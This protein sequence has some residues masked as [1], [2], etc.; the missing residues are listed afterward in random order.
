[1]K[2]RAML[3]A[4]L[5]GTLLLSTTAYAEDY[6]DYRNYRGSMMYGYERDGEFDYDSYRDF[7]DSYGYDYNDTDSLRSYLQSFDGEKS[8][9]E[10]YLDSYESDRSYRN[11]RSGRRNGFSSH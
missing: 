7:C 10:D 3:S 6:R 2:K 1:M 8:D 9:L 5:V 4:I 11:R